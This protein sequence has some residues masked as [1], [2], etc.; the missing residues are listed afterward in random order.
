MDDAVF[1]QILQ[2]HCYLGTIKQGHWFFEK[3]KDGDQ[4]FQIAANHVFHNLK[5]QNNCKTVNNRPIL[6]NERSYLPSKQMTL[7]AGS[8]TNVRNMDFS[9]VPAHFA[10]IALAISYFCW[11]SPIFA[12]SVANTNADDCEMKHL[13]AF[14]L[15]NRS[16]V[17]K[18]LDRI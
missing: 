9:T 10:P 12:F 6:T 13:L 5:T 1:V 18:Y 8:R 17:G 4:R 15:S 3:T 11:P 7:I 14:M 2:C 16:F